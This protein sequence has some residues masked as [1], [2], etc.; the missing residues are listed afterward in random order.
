MKLCILGANGQ[1]GRELVLLAKQQG[2]NHSAVSR[3]QCDVCDATAVALFIK[4]DQ[5]SIVINA[6][7]YT[8]VDKAQENSAQAYAVNAEA[9]MT[10][11]KICQQYQIPLL[12]ISTDY[13]FDGTQSTPYQETDP[14]QALGVY[15]ASK[16]AGEQAIASYCTQHVIMRTSWVF[17]RFGQNFVKT[18]LRLG[19]TKQQLSV[20]ADQFGKPTAAHAIAQALIAIAQQITAGHTH[21][22]IFHF[23]GDTALSWYDFAREI[24]ATAKIPMELE[25]LTTSQYPTLAKRPAYSVLDTQKIVAAYGVQPPV[26]ADSLNEVIQYLEK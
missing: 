1:V 16:L 5:P 8:A 3:E 20:V 9:V 11:A 26:L 12:H 2:I 7:A 21:W 25:A 19:Q 18:M 22:G 14:T 17:G 6:T 13:V 10:I 15:G 4:N 24:F 23:A